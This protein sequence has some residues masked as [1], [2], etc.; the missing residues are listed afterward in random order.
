MKFSIHMNDLEA[1]AKE[2]CGEGIDAKV[3]LFN[4]QQGLDIGPKGID[5]SKLPPNV[6]AFFFPLWELNAERNRPLVEN[7]QFTDIVLSRP[8]GWK[9]DIPC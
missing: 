1:A 4:G 9:P 7:R 3:T 6:T 2:L 8:T 5:P